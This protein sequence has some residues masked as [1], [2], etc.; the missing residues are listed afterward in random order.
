MP[1]TLRDPVSSLTHLSAAVLAVFVTLLF[2]RLTWYDRAKCRSMLVFG[3]S[4]VVLY[5]ASGVYHAINLPFD[6]TAVWVARRID[7]SAIYILIA[8]SFTPVLMVILADTWAWRLLPWVWGLALA[9]VAAKWFWPIAPD[10]LT[11]G[12]Y[13]ALGWIGV[14]PA[15]L[16]WRRVGPGCVGWS[17]LGGL[18]YTAG[19]VCDL[20]GW[21][22]LLPGWFGPHEV[23]HVCD[24]AGTSAHVILMFRYVVPFPRRYNDL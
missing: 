6:S 18:L 7:H 11:T 22:N 19:A 14:L 1:F 4:M 12:L 16:L 21:P 8:G 13:L 17:A 20:V 23:L 3:L 10:P 24:M 9:G 15:I 2:V 5:T